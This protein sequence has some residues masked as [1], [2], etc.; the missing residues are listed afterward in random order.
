MTEEFHALTG[1]RRFHAIDVQTWDRQEHTNPE[2]TAYFM[3]GRGEMTVE[4]ERYEVRPGT[5]VYVEEGAT[6]SIRNIDERGS[7][8]HYYVMEY[9]EQDRMWNQRGYPEIP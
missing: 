4:G 9:T 8:L 3:R 7:P 1:A 5:L 2:E 6:H